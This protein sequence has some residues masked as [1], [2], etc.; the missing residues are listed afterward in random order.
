MIDIEKAEEAVDFLRDTAKRIAELWEQA[1]KKENLLKHTEGLL[2]KKYHGEKVPVTLCKSYARADQKYQEAI[3]EDAIA[4][5]ELKGLE[6][7]RDAAK[8]TI[9]LYQSQVKDRL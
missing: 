2:E 7:R 1:R 6:A 8:I 3:D 4:T 9:G 5:A